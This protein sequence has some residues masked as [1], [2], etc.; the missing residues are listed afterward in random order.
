MVTHIKFNTNEY[1][2]QHKLLYKVFSACNQ[3]PGSTNFLEN[4]STEFEINRFLPADYQ[5][6]HP[7]L[8]VKKYLDETYE[9]TL[10]GIFKSLKSEP[11]R[12]TNGRLVRVLTSSAAPFFVSFTFTVKRCAGERLILSIS[13]CTVVYLKPCQTSITEF[14]CENS[15][16]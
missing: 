5:R 15:Q 6:L 4:I 7:E 16:R 2:P 12:N 14:Y 9:N 1:L 10:L 13:S 8:C 3:W 11:K